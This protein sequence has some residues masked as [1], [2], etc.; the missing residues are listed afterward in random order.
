M[1]ETA[2]T[3]ENWQPLGC[4]FFT[5]LL[6]WPASNYLLGSPT[7]YLFLRQVE[8]FYQEDCHLSPGD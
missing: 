4:Q 1:Q 3:Y 5:L 8:R 7:Y 6:F 2:K